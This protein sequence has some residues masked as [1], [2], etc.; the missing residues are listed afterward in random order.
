M[1]GVIFPLFLLPRE[2]LVK[3]SVKMA[4]NSV[5]S[6]HFSSAARGFHTYKHIWTPVMSEVLE[7]GSYKNYMV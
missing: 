5:H 1:L 2:I 6:A 3:L 4:D 7:V